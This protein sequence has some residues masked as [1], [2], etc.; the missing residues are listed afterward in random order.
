MASPVGI[1]RLLAA[2]ALLEAPPSAGGAGMRIV[3]A[4]GESRAQ[5]VLRAIRALG[6]QE[7]A[8]LKL[9]VDWIQDYGF[10]DPSHDVPRGEDRTVA[11]ALGQLKRNLAQPV[12]ITAPVPEKPRAPAPVLLEDPYIPYVDDGDDGD[13]DAA[14]QALASAQAVVERPRGG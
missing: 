3:A 14:L 9:H 2:G 11:D 5:A 6:P 1:G 8:T 12:P 4:P 13:D 7:A 10:D